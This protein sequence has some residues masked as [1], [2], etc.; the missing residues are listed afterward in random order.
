[1]LIGFTAPTAG[2][3]SAADN[4]TRIVI[5]DEAMGFDYATFSDHVAR[6]LVSARESGAVVGHLVLVPTVSDTEQE[7]AARDLVDRGDLLGGLDRVALSNQANAGSE[8]Q[9][10]VTAAATPSTTNGSI[11]S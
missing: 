8:P 7:T 1:M 6:Q 5:G 10:L 3:L 11:T 2:P 9:R 4:L